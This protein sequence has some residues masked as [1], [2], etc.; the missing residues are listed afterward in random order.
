MTENALIEIL[1]AT[2]NGEC[3]LQ[4]LLDSLK[5]Q[6]SQEWTI[7]A[8]DDGSTDGTLDILRRFELSNPELVRIIQGPKSLPGPMGN[9]AAL[10]E[11]SSAPYVMFCDQD[12]VW[13]PEKIQR[14]LD[15]MQKTERE[16][17]DDTPV[18]VHS[19]LRV[20]DRNL[21]VIANSFWDYQY[22]NRGKSVFGR[23]LVE[24]V[25]TGCASILNRALINAAMPIPQEAIMHDWWMALVASAFGKIVPIDDPLV[26]YR[27]HGDNNLGAMAFSFDKECVVACIGRL[28]K[29]L[30]AASI[31][32]NVFHSRF[33]DKLH[34][35]N[36]TL[37]AL[38]RMG[39]ANWLERR[40]IMFSH[41]FYLYGAA[42]NFAWLIFA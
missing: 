25:V 39:G 12:D 16:C 38:S 10:I 7:L 33:G 26:L 4:E 31:Q 41:G 18:L 21:K 3:W 32:A 15:V 27:Q 9:F 2:Y 5:A 1:L 42:K 14:L 40:C 22:L 17:P 30:I 28:R 19:D 29:R 8:R 35:C 24:N 11:A 20:V 37:V 6:T 23:L 34:L 13:L 36:R